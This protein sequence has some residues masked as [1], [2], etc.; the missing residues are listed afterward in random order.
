MNFMFKCRIPKTYTI[1]KVT[2]LCCNYIHI[3][4]KLFLSN[5]NL[6]KTMNEYFR[7]DHNHE[8]RNF[9]FYLYSTISI[10]SYFLY[11]QNYFTINILP[12]VKAATHQSIRNQYNFI[13]DVVELAKSAVVCIEINDT[14]R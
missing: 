1:I 2:P 12:E 8:S 11:K 14:H 10:L 3:S 6:S 5:A 4:S 9:K 7:H 13:A